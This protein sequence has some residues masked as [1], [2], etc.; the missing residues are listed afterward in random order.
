[1]AKFPT[2]ELA[3]QHYNALIAEG[4]NSDIIHYH[5]DNV[6]IVDE[7]Y[8]SKLN[9]GMKILG[10]HIGDD[11]YINNKIE[12]YVTDLKQKANNLINFKQNQNKFLLLYYCYVPLI[13]HYLKT[14][15]PSLTVNFCQT[16]ENLKKSILLSCLNHNAIDNNRWIQA[17]LPIN[18]SGLGM[19]FSQTVRET[20]FVASVILSYATMKKFIPEINYLEENDDFFKT[21]HSAVNKIITCQNKELNN[22]DNNNNDIIINNDNNNNN[23]INNNNDNKLNIRNIMELKS[24]K[25]YTI[26]S[27]LTKIIDNNKYDNFIKSIHDT[28]YLSLLTSLNDNSCGKWLETV[29]KNDD[30]IFTNGQYTVNLC[31]RLFLD[32]PYFVPN[33]ICNCNNKPALDSKGLHLSCCPKSG[34]TIKLH[35]AFVNEMTKLIKS[36][37]GSARTEVTDC[38]QSLTNNSL[39]RTDVNY[40]DP[41]TSLFSKSLLLDM[42]I[43]TIFEGVK[44]GQIVAVSRKNALIPFRK[45][46]VSYNLKN[47]KHKKLA[48]DNNYDFL[49]SIMESPSGRLDQNF[50]NLLKEIAKKNSEQSLNIK[51]SILYNYYLKR[52]SCVFQK[53]LSSSFLSRTGQVNGKLSMGAANNYIYKYSFI[54]DF[55]KFN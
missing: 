31:Y 52:I 10:V 1:M 18:K 25:N 12:N 26:Q 46:L 42:C 55:H 23:N 17:R 45:G 53:S 50:K 16:F 19:R 38:L 11:I 44:S 29:P 6:S 35:D 32:Q 33:S 7:Q 3:H 48:N 14:T 34:T 43:P 27:K 9:Y 49:P 21:F 30:L 4:L 39:Q 51:E 8:L 15:S 2:N 36:A 24:I 22:N 54:S 41:P 28:R 40:K 47:N 5:P 37:G 20:S 13:D